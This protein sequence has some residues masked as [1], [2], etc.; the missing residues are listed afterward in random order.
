[1]SNLKVRQFP[2]EFQNYFTFLAFE[3]KWGKNTEI[4]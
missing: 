1:M 2:L 4:E 3:P